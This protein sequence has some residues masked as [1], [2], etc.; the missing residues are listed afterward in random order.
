MA[1]FTFQRVVDSLRYS[2]AQDMSISS[3]GNGETLA[4]SSVT[5]I[6]DWG[7]AKI[8]NEIIQYT[9]VNATNKTITLASSGGRGALGSPIEAHAA[10]SAIVFSVVV[11]KHIN[12]L[13]DASPTRLLTTKG[14]IIVAAGTNAP[15]QL[16][17]GVDG[18]ALVA[19][20]TQPLGVKWANL[21]NINHSVGVYKST[22]QTL[23]VNTW[24]VISFD[25]KE[26]DNAN[27]W[28]SG[29]PTRIVI[30]ENG[31]Y[32]LTFG[33]LIAPVSA[34]W[35]YALAKPRKNGTTDLDSFSTYGTGNAG[36]GVPD[37][38]AFN[39]QA[40]LN[41]GD[42]LEFLVWVND[43]SGTN[44]VVSSVRAQVTLLTR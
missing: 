2:I 30:P 26:W 19:D 40:K 38:T 12:E 7:Y 37:R 15:Q 27:M 9:S 23:A 6:P 43:N 4:L 10:G 18:Q 16:V 42:Y 3:P 29:Q 11:S 20:S 36:I 24:T 17:T 5:G 44:P 39:L 13:V 8:G 1:D 28:S 35:R 14:G 25:A 31:V 22:S 21:N 32:L 34:N 33:S 41:T